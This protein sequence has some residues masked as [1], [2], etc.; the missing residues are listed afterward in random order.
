M[1]KE[2]NISREV[3]FPLNIGSEKALVQDIQSKIDNGDVY[4]RQPGYIRFYDDKV[5][6]QWVVAYVV[7][8]FD[9]EATEKPALEVRIKHISYEDVQGK[10]LNNPANVIDGFKTLVSWDFDGPGQDSEHRAHGVAVSAD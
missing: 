2:L 1:Y 8:P 7:Q 4:A 9:P 3:L 5:N 10:Y 6:E